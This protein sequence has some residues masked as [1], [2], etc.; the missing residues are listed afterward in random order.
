MHTLLNI[1]EPGQAMKLST[2]FYLPQCPGKLYFQATRKAFNKAAIRGSV[3]GEKFDMIRRAV[4]DDILNI[5]QFSPAIQIE[6]SPFVSTQ[7]TRVNG[8]THVF[9][10]NFTGLKGRKRA[11]QIPEKGVTISLKTGS[12]TRIRFLPFLG[13]IQEIQ[14]DWKEGT[15]TCVLPDIEKGAVVWFE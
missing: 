3:Q 9:F 11:Q 5:L 15:L 10:A 12:D 6:A 8:H 2:L 4:N 7:T 14:G 13:E 1:A